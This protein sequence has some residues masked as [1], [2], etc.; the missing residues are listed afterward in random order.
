MEWKVF[1]EDHPYLRLNHFHVP[2]FLFQRELSTWPRV[3]LNSPYQ[4]SDLKVYHLTRSVQKVAICEEQMVLVFALQVSE[5][6]KDLVTSWAQTT[7]F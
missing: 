3:E 7:I 5:L 6:A 4:N 2:T 1:Q